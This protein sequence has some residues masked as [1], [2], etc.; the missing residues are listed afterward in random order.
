MLNIHIKYKC[1]LRNIRWYCVFNRSAIKLN[2]TPKPKAVALCTVPSSYIT[3]FL[4]RITSFHFKKRCY[5]RWY[6][7]AFIVLVDI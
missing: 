1:S 6:I 5:H 2:I 7:T 4:T 3:E